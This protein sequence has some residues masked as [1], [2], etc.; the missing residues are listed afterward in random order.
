MRITDSI[1]AGFLSPD[2]CLRFTQIFPG[3]L[4]SFKHHVFIEFLHRLQNFLNF[5][6]GY[7]GIKIPFFTFKPESD[8]SIF[9]KGPF[10][11]LHYIDFLCLGMNG[12][13]E[14]RQ[15]EAAVR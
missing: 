1:R 14:A 2:Y 7:T 9:E 10:R 3:F 5:L 11:S 4:Q 13:S 6:I 12:T 8:E 15:F